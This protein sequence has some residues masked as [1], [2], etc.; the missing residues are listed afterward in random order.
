MSESWDS[1]EV[2]KAVAFF[3]RGKRDR[4]RIFRLIGPEEGRAPRSSPTSQARVAADARLSEKTR[5]LE[6]A[7]CSRE[8]L[9]HTTQVA[10]TID[11]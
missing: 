9:L 5:S 4:V 6:R 8:L 2:G 7:A 3:A 11:R 1:P 10:I